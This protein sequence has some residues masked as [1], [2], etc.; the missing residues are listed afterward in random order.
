MPRAPVGILLR[1]AC[2][3]L[4]RI[5][6]RGAPAGILGGSVSLVLGLARVAEHVQRAAERVRAEV[7]AVAAEISE[8]AVPNRDRA[9]G[10]AARTSLNM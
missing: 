9:L 4:P 8:Q 2:A 7:P 5:C 6:E 3:L 1:A 10:F